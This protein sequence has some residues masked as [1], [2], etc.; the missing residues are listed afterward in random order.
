MG[1]CGCGGGAKKVGE[2]LVG[3]MRTSTKR[4]VREKLTLEKAAAVAGPTPGM[5]VMDSD[6]EMSGFMHQ[7]LMASVE[8]LDLSG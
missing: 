8:E 4:T 6:E 1:G 3:E 2:K 5:T 7:S